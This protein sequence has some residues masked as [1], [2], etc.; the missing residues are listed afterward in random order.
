MSTRKNQAPKETRCEGGGWIYELT[1]GGKNR[2]T[3]K[4]CSFAVKDL[5]RE[6]P[7]S[8]FKGVSRFLAPQD[9]ITQ[10]RMYMS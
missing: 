7:F 10:I 6:L 1:V 9:K 5:W 2:T 4:D 8:N 3:Q